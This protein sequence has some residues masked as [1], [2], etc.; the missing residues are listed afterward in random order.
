[1]EYA[2]FMYMLP[3]YSCLFERRDLKYHLQRRAQNDDVFKTVG[4]P[5]LGRVGTGCIQEAIDCCKM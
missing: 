4:I 5:Q 2:V 3:K 1:M